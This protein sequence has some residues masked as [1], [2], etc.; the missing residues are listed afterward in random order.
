MAAA[1]ESPSPSDGENGPANGGDRESSR[2]SR[3]LLFYSNE[4]ANR[5]AWADGGAVPFA[6]G[7]WSPRLRRRRLRHRRGRRRKRPHGR[8]RRR[9]RKHRRRFGKAEVG[10]AVVAGR[11]VERNRRRRPRCLH[12]SRLLS[13]GRPV[14]LSLSDAHCFTAHSPPPPAR[15][16]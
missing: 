7:H 13:R 5:S 6:C 10:N 9:R 16:R 8:G 4:T 14:G 12:G 3:Q 1:E 2:T 11:E 15:Q